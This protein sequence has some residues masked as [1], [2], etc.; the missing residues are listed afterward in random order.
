M[1][2]WLKEELAETE[3]IL[4][5]SIRL[6]GTEINATI[7]EVG[8]ELSDQ[9][10]FT[11]EDLKELVDYAMTSLDE[12]VDRRVSKLRKEMTLLILVSFAA[13][14]VGIVVTWIIFRTK[15]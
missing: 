5:D 13:V 14:M 11:K 2:N 15:G 6:A 8:R 4:Q 9:R 3:R 10:R 1:A 7:K 12:V